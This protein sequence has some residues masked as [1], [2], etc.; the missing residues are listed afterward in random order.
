[1][2][3]DPT[4]PRVRVV[5]VEDGLAALEPQHEGVVAPHGVDAPARVTAGQREGMAASG[6]RRILV[7]G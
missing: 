5:Q 1:M 7:G 2:V 6:S 3:R 4:L